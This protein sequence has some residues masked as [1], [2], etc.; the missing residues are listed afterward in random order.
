[1]PVSMKDVAKAAGVTEGTVSRA[2]SDSARVNPETRERIQALAHDM[3][4]VPSAIARGLAVRRTSTLGVMISDF[5]DPFIARLMLA[6]DRQALQHGYSIILSSAGTD[7]EREVSAIRLLLQQRV[8]A[9][10]VLDPLV[11]DSSLPQLE[12]FGVP[13]V[14]LNRKRYAH[15]VGTDNVAAGELAAGYLLDLGHRRVAYIGGN[16]SMEESLDRQTG[17]E[18]ALDKRG[19]P[20]DPALILQGDGSVESGERGLAQL[21]AL[22]DP[23]TAVFCFNDI[24]AA[25]AFLYAYRTGLHVPTDLSVV[26][27]DDSIASY[28]V[29]PLTTVAQAVEELARLSLHMA[30]GLLQGNELPQALNVAGQLM[31]RQSTAPP[32]GESC[33]C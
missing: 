22:S 10:I 31:V 26:G 9:I 32:R 19:I 28:L 15:S 18:F 20:V 29:P 27:F 23:P 5:G 12:H 30:L 2:L 6:L 4:Y 24:T 16:R 13:L 33:T 1:M 17:Y 14:L 8:D 21:L 3:G 11:A 25:G 7:P